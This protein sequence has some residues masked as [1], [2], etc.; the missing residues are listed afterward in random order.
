MH[1]TGYSRCRQKILLRLGD[2][3]FGT[4][5]LRTQCERSEGQDVLLLHPLL[6]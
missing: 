4:A 2:F 5:Q 1:S 6:P 3:G